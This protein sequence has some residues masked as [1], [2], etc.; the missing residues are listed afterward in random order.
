MNVSSKIIEMSVLLPIK[1]EWF[2]MIYAG[3]KKQEY[4][5]IGNYW[6][7]RLIGNW[8]QYAGQNVLYKGDHIKRWGKEFLMLRNGYAA[9][10]PTIIVEWTSIEV[11]LPNPDWCPKDTDLSK[12][13]FCANLG[14]VIWSNCERV[15]LIKKQNP[16][17]K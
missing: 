4:R 16:H 6:G 15:E 3:I 2:D 7:A 14:E 12:H 17:E 1:K 11:G 13:V 8:H 10:D 5:G 9:T